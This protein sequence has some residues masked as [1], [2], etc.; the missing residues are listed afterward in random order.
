MRPQAKS[1]GHADAGLQPERT[2]L[3]W[4]RTLLAL[5]V[6]GCLFL[7]WAPTHHFLAI[8]PAALAL[9]VALAI[10]AGLRKRYQRSVSG[11]VEERMVSSIESVLGLAACLAVLSLFEIGALL[12]YG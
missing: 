12:L 10:R 9:M 3:A 2:L 8:L 7:R 11:I 1:L 5:I 6:C 4:N